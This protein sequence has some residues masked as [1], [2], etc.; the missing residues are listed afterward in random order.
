M[1]IFRLILA[2]TRP[3]LLLATA[4][5]LSYVPPMMCGHVTALNFTGVTW[6]GRVRRENGHFNANAN[7]TIFS[8][9]YRLARYINIRPI[10]LRN[11]VT[12]LLPWYRLNSFEVRIP[13]SLFS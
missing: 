10:V 2:T 5:N 11:V 9:L 4:A 3:F 12:L 1:D 6:H 13:V 8:S 7:N